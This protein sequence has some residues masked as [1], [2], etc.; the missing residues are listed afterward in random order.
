MILS[1]I[2]TLETSFIGVGLSAPFYNI[3]IKPALKILNLNT[4]HT[5]RVKF[6]KS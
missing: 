2:N 1:K 4:S 5:R 6:I 3:D